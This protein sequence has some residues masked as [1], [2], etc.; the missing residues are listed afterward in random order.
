M[1]ALKD[2]EKGCDEAGAWDDV[3]KWLHNYWVP[4]IQM[5]V[6]HSWHLPRYVDAPVS[7]AVLCEKM[8]GFFV[9]Y[10]VWKPNS[11]NFSGGLR[12]IACSHEAMLYS[13]SFRKRKVT[14]NP[15]MTVTRVRR[16][17]LNCITGCSSL[18]ITVHVTKTEPRFIGSF[19]KLNMENN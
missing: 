17:R 2:T 11:V 16:R 5:Q 13:P 9:H 1:A 14:L 19:T 4:F 3:R 15:I 12:I 8:K 10:T 6:E 18:Y 7:H